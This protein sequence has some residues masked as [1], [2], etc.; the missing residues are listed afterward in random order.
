MVWYNAELLRLKIRRRCDYASPGELKRPYRHFARTKG[1]AGV[2]LDDF[3]VALKDLGFRLSTEQELEIFKYFSPTQSN[4]LFHYQDFVVFTRDPFFQD[5]VWKLRRLMARSRTS[6]AEIETTLSKCQ[7]LNT[8]LVKLVNS[9]Q[10]SISLKSCNIELTQ[11]DITRLVAKFDTDESDQ[12]DVSLFIGFLRGSNE[13]QAPEDGRM[14]PNALSNSK[15]SIELAAF[16]HLREKVEQRMERGYSKNEIFSEFVDRPRGLLDLNAMQR[17]SRELGVLMSQAEARAVLRRMTNIAGGPIDQDSLYLALQISV[18]DK[19]KVDSSRLF[20]SRQIASNRTI[21]DSE[22][23]DKIKSGDWRSER[24]GHFDYAADDDNLI[25]ATEDE[26]ESQ[27]MENS[28]DEPWTVHDIIVSIRNHVSAEI[29]KFHY[30]NLLR[31][32]YLTLL[33]TLT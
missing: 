20:S 6:I 27:R 3:R 9:N 24:H 16:R 10:L 1:V 33:Y 26:W 7:N 32:T 11:R 12:V 25:Q 2:S 31:L 4:S 19:K 21:D 14:Q 30:Y 28:T 17:G 22:V 8:Y 18:S 15:E 29:K 23:V 13:L 5:V